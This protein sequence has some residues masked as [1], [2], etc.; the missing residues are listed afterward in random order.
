MRGGQ[1]NVLIH[2]IVV[3]KTTGVKFGKSEAGAVWLTK[4]N[5]AHRFLPIL[6]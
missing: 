1:A 2:P 5:I 3:N 4:Q 6:D